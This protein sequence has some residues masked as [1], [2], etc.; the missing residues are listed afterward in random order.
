MVLRGFG[1]LRLVRLS[2]LGVGAAF[3]TPL[4]ACSSNPGCGMTLCSGTPAFA[5][6]P[7]ALTFNALG[8][9][10]QQTVTINVPSQQ[11]A[12][13][14]ESDN[15][16]QGATRIVNVNSPTEPQGGTSTV[17][18]T[19]VANGSCA[20]TFSGGPGIAGVTVPVTVAAP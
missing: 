13:P 6:K 11:S 19:P 18:V 9:A 14:T 5:A 17:A 7:Q 3:L 12:A 15:C 10:A 16:T 8:T 4:G 20:L 1:W 2:L